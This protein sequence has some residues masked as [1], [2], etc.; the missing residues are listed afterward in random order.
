M[1]T[2]EGTAYR[3]GYIHKNGSTLYSVT[4]SFSNAPTAN[5][6]LDSTSI[7]IV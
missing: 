5:V 2:A 3:G 4:D 1:G 7:S 6:L